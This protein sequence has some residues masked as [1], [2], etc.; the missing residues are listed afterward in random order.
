MAKE[1]NASNEKEDKKNEDKP[2]QK[3]GAKAQS[4][5]KSNTKKSTSAKSKSSSAK[6]KNAS[7]KTAASKKT[8]ASK[9]KQ[10]TA[11]K[12]KSSASKAKSSKSSA[13]KKSKAKKS[14]GKNTKAK[15]AAVKKVEKPKKEQKEIEKDKPETVADKQEESDALKQ[16]AQ[17]R[18]VE[19]EKID[20][21]AEVA[22][23][24]QEKT[25]EQEEA[26]EKK[27]SER[28]KQRLDPGLKEFLKIREE[29][30]GDPFVKTFTNIGK[31]IANNRGPIVISLLLIAVIIFLLVWNLTKTLKRKYGA[32]ER[33]AAAKSV[34]DYK[35]LLQTEQQKETYPLIY[36]YLIEQ[37]DKESGLSLIK[38][39]E[40]KVRYTEQF[41][42]EFSN[43]PDWTT[44]CNY[45]SSKLPIWQRDLELLKQRESQLKS[46]PQTQPAQKN[47]EIIPSNDA[48]PLLVSLKTRFG[49][50]ELEL[51]DKV[52]PNTVKAF[53]YLLREGFYNEN[54]PGGFIT[55]ERSSSG[56]DRLVF[57]TFPAIDAQNRTKKYDDLKDKDERV[58]KLAKKWE[59][60]FNERSIG[61]TLPFE[62]QGIKQPCKAGA[63]LLWLDNSNHLQSGS[64]KIAIL[65]GDDEELNGKYVVFGSIKRVSKNLK[66]EFYQKICD[67][68]LD[69]A[70]LRTTVQINRT[71][72]TITGYTIKRLRAARRKIEL[73]VEQKKGVYKSVANPYYVQVDKNGK[74][75][76]AASIEDAD[77]LRVFPGQLEYIPKGTF[78]KNDKGKIIEA[79]KDVYL[80]HHSAETLKFIRGFAAATPP[81]SGLITSTASLIAG[82]YAFIKYKDIAIFK[83]LFDK[84]GKLKPQEYKPKV[85]YNDL[86]IPMLV[87]DKPPAK[88]GPFVFTK[89]KNSPLFSTPRS[90]RPP[91][92][93]MPMPDNNL[94]PG[95]S[96]TGRPGSSLPM[97][98]GTSTPGLPFG[99]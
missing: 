49:E 73:Y 81:F 64:T 21:E 45:Y 16:D 89:D 11:S 47:I 83:D 36:I 69:A 5:K 59:V 96:P 42:D 75:Y 43:N 80:S 60:R 26:E 18:T 37:F 70:S 58:K 7:K 1:K 94:P 24:E 25:E 35:K 3:K 86:P 29:K 95:V 62:P 91:S 68:P 66:E 65:L 61:W 53:I 92:R 98:P 97:N 74:E 44:Y 33:L 79:K 56:I 23:E 4:A 30:K 22:E 54:G 28:R 90:R 88:T 46:P 15:K 52:A 38:K 17:D 99:R 93:P 27:L 12:S 85:L 67:A 76:I 55:R 71:G 2:K 20:A 51:F 82:S 48:R 31:W 57:G 9:K 72:T 40:G 39:L 84:D 87:R 10:S 41:L 77:F 8:T 78:Y 13:S 32:W 14:T 6:K 34:T 19:Q 63:V 50:I